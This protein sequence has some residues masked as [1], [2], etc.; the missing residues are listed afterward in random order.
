MDAA[1][2]FEGQ[3][4]R[5]GPALES[6]LGLRAEIFLVSQV[7]NYFP[8]HLVQVMW[9]DADVEVPDYGLL[10]PACPQVG[11][12]DGSV[13]GDNCG[14]GSVVVGGGDVGT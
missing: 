9:G 7:K 14:D 2:S 10:V 5:T 4:L 12:G 1:S 11:G 13:V 8:I 3:P 6:L